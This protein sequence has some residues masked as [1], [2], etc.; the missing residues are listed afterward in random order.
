MSITGMPTHNL[1][2]SKFEGLPLDVLDRIL[3]T[4]PNWRSLR[5]AILSCKA[6]YQAYQFRRDNI[7]KTVV[8]NEVGPTLNYL[9]VVVRGLRDVELGGSNAYL[10]SLRL[11]DRSSVYW[12]EAL[13]EADASEISSNKMGETVS[14]L[15]E[16]FTLRC[17]SCFNHLEVPSRSM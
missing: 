15:E 14:R 1:A 10:I 3:I 17:A 7:L 12:H 4:L 2:V 8:E 13:T 5:S 6:L 11:N 16:E 9:L